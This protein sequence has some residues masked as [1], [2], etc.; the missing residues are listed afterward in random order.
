MYTNDNI[1]WYDKIKWLEK[2][3]KSTLDYIFKSIWVNFRC[4]PKTIG[5]RFLDAF[6]KSKFHLDYL[7]E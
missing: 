2:S 7:Y 5:W 1:N 6:Y 3:L 4:Y